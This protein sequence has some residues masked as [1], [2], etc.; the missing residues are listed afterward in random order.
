MLGAEPETQNR[1][2]WRLCVAEAMDVAALMAAAIAAV[3]LPE[4]LWAFDGERAFAVPIV[5]AVL[6]AA[7][8]GASRALFLLCESGG[9]ACA[10]ADVECA[11]ALRAASRRCRGG[12]VAPPPRS[13]P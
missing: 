12:A 3:I 6:T 8:A 5:G 4:K 2:L 9:D 1:A 10:D 7:L 11:F 13:L